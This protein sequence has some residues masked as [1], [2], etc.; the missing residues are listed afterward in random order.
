PSFQLATDIVRRLLSKNDSIHDNDRCIAA[1]A[2]TA[3]C[4]H[5][6]LAIRRRLAWPDLQ[7]LAHGREQSVGILD[8]A[9]RSRANDAG[10]PPLRLEREEVVERRD[11]I[12]ATGRK[13][14]TARD[15][16]EQV[17]FEI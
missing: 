3:S 1:G 12:D 13:L 10:V 17:V 6:N 16:I 9:R 15:V 4:Q 8:V 5:G 7:L 2:K 11:T 14:Q